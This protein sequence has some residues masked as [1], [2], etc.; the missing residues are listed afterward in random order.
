MVLL[1]GLITGP[2]FDRGY[3]TTLI[4]VGTFLIV[5]GHM[6]L[7]LTHNFWQALLAQGF[8]IGFGAGCLY[9]PSI[10]IMPTYFTT[11]IGLAIGLAASGSSMGGIIYPIMFYKLIRECAVPIFDQVYPLLIFSMHLAQVGY[12]WSVRIIGFTSLATLLIPLAIMRIRVKPGKIRKI[13]DWS[14]FVDLPYMFFA[15]GCVIGFIGLYVALFYTSYY[16]QANHITDESLSFYL[17]PILNAGSVFGRTLPN[18]LSDKIGP[19]NVLV[20]GA[21]SVGILLLCYLAATNVGGLVVCTLLF[22]FASGIFI[23]LP[24]VLFAALTKDKSLVGTRMG[25]GFAM[26]SVGVLSG[27][28][29]AGSIL[30][31]GSTNLD[32]TGTWVYAGVA[33][34]VAGSIFAILRIMKGGF[35]LMVKV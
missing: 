3:L 2:I 15:I 31:T 12:P 24:P 28:P 32:W 26:I 10:A 35:K 16:G 18:W 30:G 9:I 21:L 8:T 4:A 34:L 11:N 14:A 23:A 1:S 20:P 13:I 33:A 17:V 25:M 29:G 5:F 6:M 27:G 22:G 19:L 7:S